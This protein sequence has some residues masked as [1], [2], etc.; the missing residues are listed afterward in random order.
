MLSFSRNL[1]PYLLKNNEKA[2]SEKS[3][4]LGVIDHAYGQGCAA[5]WVKTQLLT[6][7]LIAG[8][9][10]PADMAALD[11][12]SQ[13]FVAKYGH[14]KLTEFLLFCARFSL[15]MYGR[16]Y[17]CFDPIMIGNNFSKFLKE[18]RDELDIIERKRNMAEHEK[19]MSVEVER[20]HQMPE[21]LRKR[22]MGGG[23]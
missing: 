2:Y 13:L 5:L 23:E 20:D 12:F 14:I 22:L 4:V 17:G 7:D 1:Q 9:K 8:L 6:I 19:L 16:F 11:K 18:R 15:G 21:E 3:P 10:E